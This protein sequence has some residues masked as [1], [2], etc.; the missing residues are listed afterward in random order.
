[1]KAKLTSR[2]EKE[3]TPAPFWSLPQLGSGLE[4]LARR[5]KLEPSAVPVPHPNSSLAAFDAPTRSR[6]S[7]NRWSE[8]A[9]DW[10]GVE[11]EPSAIPY[12]GLEQM[13]ENAGPAVLQ[14]PGNGP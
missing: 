12:E 10:L 4:A 3:D 13:L 5:S 11:A 6:H 1:M 9:A 7:S 14:V 8:S 2:S